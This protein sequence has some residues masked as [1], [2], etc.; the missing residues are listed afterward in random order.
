MPQYCYCT[1]DGL[2][3]EKT[4]QMGHAPDEITL[5][6][7]K[8]ATRDRRAELAGSTISV[9]G[10]GGSSRAWPMA[11]CASG[12]HPSQA[13]ELREHLVKRGCKTEVTPGGD[14]VYTS[15]EHRKK[16]LK[17]RGMHDKNSFC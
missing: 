5:P 6:N 3:V 13:G 9:R 14:P 8:V 17:I 16:A 4:F 11:C 15:A 1:E 2:L 12:V 7:G 10:G